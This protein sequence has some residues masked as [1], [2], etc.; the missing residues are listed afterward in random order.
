MKANQIK[1]FNELPS[2]TNGLKSAA[3]TK[4]QNLSSLYPDATRGVLAP[5]K[6]PKGNIE[7]KP[8]NKRF[9]FWRILN[10][11]IIVLVVVLAFFTIR[12]VIRYILGMVGA[13]G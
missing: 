2:G 8:L 7:I 13:A 3:V 1:H 6:R 4:G 10:L 9:G 5:H 12:F 11:L